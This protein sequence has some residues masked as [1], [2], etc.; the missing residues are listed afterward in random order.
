VLAALFGQNVIIT[1]LVIGLTSWPQTARIIRSQ[2][3]SLRERP[4]IQRIRSLGANDSR[5]MFRHILPN[6]APLIFANLAL[7]L[8]G[9]SWPR[10]HWRS[11]D[12]AT[13]C[14]FLGAPCCTTRLM[15]AL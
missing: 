13:R 12:W 5:I 3:L 2:V 6:V 4:L 10:P 1:S 9:R 15:P 14:R 11:S 7:V 8:S